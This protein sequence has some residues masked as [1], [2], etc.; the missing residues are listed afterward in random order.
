V[1]RKSAT[2]KL[3]NHNFNRPAAS[4]LLL[5]LAVSLLSPVVTGCG[6]VK[7]N[8]ESVSEEPVRETEINESAVVEPLPDIEQATA[9]QPPPP[10]QVVGF[11]TAGAM[12]H[13]LYLADT[14]GQRVEATAGEGQAAQYIQDRLVEYGY[15]PVQQV[16]PIAAAG[17][18]SVNVIAA[19]PG[20]QRPEFKIIVGAHMDTRN[21]SGPSPG[22]NDNATGCAVVLELARVLSSNKR[23][24]P[25]VE[26]VFFGGEEVAEGGGQDDHHFGSRQYVAGLTPETRSSTRGMISVDMVGFGSSFLVRNMKK[27][28]QTLVNLL[29][30]YGKARGLSYLADTGSSGLS[31][32]EPF[33]RAGMPS[34][35]IE[36]RNDEAIHG[37]GDTSAHVDSSKV[38]NTGQ[39]LQGFFEEYLTPERLVSLL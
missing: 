17:G 3:H 37:P 25:T 23:N 21:K 27:A 33:E 18:D 39:F 8:N 32:H 2:L 24:V 34:A 22:G 12:S 28:P 6:Q 19:L 14:I 15:S 36:Y 20:G 5:I 10:P 31:D 16:V 29:L 4:L 35:W 26:F 7:K 9:A 38:G 11:D 13:V 1:I 30:E